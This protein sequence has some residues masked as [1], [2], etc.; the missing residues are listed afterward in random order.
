MKIINFRENNLT[1][2]I[3]IMNKSTVALAAD[4]AVTIKSR[5]NVKIFNSVNKLFALQDD[6]PVGIMIYNSATINGVGWEQLFKEY[7]INRGNK[8]FDH[9][10]DYATDFVS[11]IEKSDFFPEEVQNRMLKEEIINIILDMDVQHKK[12]Q[13]QSPGAILDFGLFIDSK[14][15]EF[16]ALPKNKNADNL[17]TPFAQQTIKTLVNEVIEYFEK[18]RGMSFDGYNNEIIDLVVAILKTVAH[19]NYS[20]IVISGF[21]FKDLFP[22]MV[23]LNIQ[24][25]FNNYLKYHIVKTHSI[26]FE[27]ESVIVPFAQSQ[28]VDNFL[29]GIDPEIQ[30]YMYSFV[31]TM[32]LE[33]T[34]FVKRLLSDP[35]QKDAF[36]KVMKSMAHTKLKDYVETLNNYKQEKFIQP[37]VESVKLLPKEE[38]A[39]MAETLV[40]ITSFKR[41]M[42]I[43]DA[44][45]VGGPIDVAVI[46][47]GDGLI[48]IKRK[49]YF[50]AELNQSYMRRKGKA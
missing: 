10:D 17:T 36:E 28:V 13:N 2:E 43:G 44:E 15:Q 20:G 22:S 47:K 33:Y 11:F 12:I 29:T 48:W 5:D 3:L 1:A 21:G 16:D 9:L 4:S 50:D 19:G 38:L 42:V 26:T 46:S 14:I 8:V 37:I 24:F 35:T 7:K 45:T 18:S 23:E 49:H 25:M 30:N 39:I 27:N 32:T 6:I 40:S 31:E 34:D 41:K